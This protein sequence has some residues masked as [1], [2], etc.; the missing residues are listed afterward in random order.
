[1]TE[2]K[3]K[4]T[5]RADHGWRRDDSA[6]ALPQRAFINYELNKE[7]KEL[8]K[9]DFVPKFETGTA[10][11]ALTQEGYTVTL[12]YDQHTKAFACWVYHMTPEHE[13]GGLILT[14]RGSLANSALIEV[15]FKH[16]VLFD[17]VW[18]NAERN[19]PNKS[20]DEE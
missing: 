3:K 12:R 20:W 13:N 16:F 17:K 18:P 14:G 7:E 15:A 1:M 8:L 6:K 11:N 2:N 5:P 4:A 19:A 9:R 10:L